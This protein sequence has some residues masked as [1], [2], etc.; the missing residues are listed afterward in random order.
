MWTTIYISP[1]SEKA[2][3][4]KKL[5]ESEGIIAK[6]KTVGNNENNEWFFEILVPS[7]EISEAHSIIIDSE[8]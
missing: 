3:K 8:L 7:K 5:L 1:K 4:I 2:V 6:N